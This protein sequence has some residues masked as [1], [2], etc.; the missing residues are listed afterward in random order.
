MPSKSVMI[1][2][3][4]TTFF[5]GK[6]GLPLRISANMHPM[7]QMS[8]AGVYLVK[9]APA[10]LWRAVPPRGDV[11]R[12]EHGRRSAVVERRPREAKVADLQLAVRVG[13]DVLGLEVAVVHVRGVNVLESQQLYRFG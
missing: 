13:E 3:W 4:C 6:M 1:S 5:P 10:Q 7:L 11:V 8:I 9:N 12:P 2:S